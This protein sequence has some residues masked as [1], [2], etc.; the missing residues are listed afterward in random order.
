MLEHISL[1]NLVKHSC[2]DNYAPLD[3]GD[4]RIN[5]YFNRLKSSI[6]AKGVLVPLMAV[7]RFGIEQTMVF[8]GWLR[9]LAATDLQM[10]HVPVLVSDT[11]ISDI[12]VHCRRMIINHSRYGHSGGQLKRDIRPVIEAKPGLKIGE[13]TKEVGMS[14]EDICYIIGFENLVGV[15]VEAF[16]GGKLN[17]FAAYHLARIDWR[18]QDKLLPELLEAGDDVERCKRVFNDAK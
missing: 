4:L 16:I 2:L 14:I 15:V 7:R 11:A 12:E 1:E 6:E 8:D 13:I 17:W 10:A 9:Y 18:Y 3:G 5:S